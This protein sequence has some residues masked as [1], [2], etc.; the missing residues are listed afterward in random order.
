MCKKGMYWLSNFLCINLKITYL[1][2]FLGPP[3]INYATHPRRSALTPGGTQAASTTP[4]PASAAAPSTH[5]SNSNPLAV[6]AIDPEW[7]DINICSTSTS[8]NPDAPLVTQTATATSSIVDGHD[9][10]VNSLADAL[11]G[12]S[13]DDVPVAHVT[14][15]Q[16]PVPAPV[17]LPTGRR[18]GKA[19]YYSVIVGKCCGVYHSW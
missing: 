18:H 10:S 17:V 19:K 1:Y 14:V 15:T 8:P 7:L 6:I 5:S 2:L 13:T 9:H 3:P 12:L 4:Q 16:P 11:D